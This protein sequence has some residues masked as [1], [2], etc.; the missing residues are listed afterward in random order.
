MGVGATTFDKVVLF[1]RCYRLIRLAGRALMRMLVGLWRCVRKRRRR[2]R[3]VSLGWE[4]LGERVAA[5]LRR[6]G[7]CSFF[8]ERGWFSFSETAC[9]RKAIVFNYL[10]FKW[11]SSTQWSSNG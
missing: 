6:K 10:F 4:G 8:L 3:P 7:C 11:N 2:R 1:T 5:F 9:G